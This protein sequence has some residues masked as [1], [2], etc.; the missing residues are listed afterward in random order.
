MS[1]KIA[2]TFTLMIF[3]LLFFAALSLFAS[4]APILP[5]SLSQNTILILP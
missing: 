2:T 5:E 3:L 4:S 1:H